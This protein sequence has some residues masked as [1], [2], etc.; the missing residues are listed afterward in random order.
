MLKNCMII[1]LIQILFIQCGSHNIS[2]DNQIKVFELSD[3]KS[4]S[5]IT[6]CGLTG[7]TESPAEHII[8]EVE[9]PFFVQEIKGKIINDVGDGWSKESR[10]L[11]EIRRTSGGPVRRTLADERGNFIMKHIADGQYCFKATVLGWQSVMGIIIVNKKGG[12]KSEI[13][14]S[15]RLGV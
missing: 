13:V 6:L 3:H 9:E 7:F 2:R 15:M 4:K 11:F 10:V 5:W 12:Q 8:N 1:L 14:F